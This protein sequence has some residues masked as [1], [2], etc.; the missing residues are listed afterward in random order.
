[1][2]P[3][4]E[5]F[6]PDFREW[7]AWLEPVKASE[8][9]AEQQAALEE[10]GPHVKN[11]EFARLLVREASSMRERGKLLNQIMY[12]N[13]GLPRAERELA[14]T[15]ESL[16]NGCAYCYSVHARLYI[17]LS[18]QVET[19]A[20]LREH[21]FAAELNDRQRAIVDFSV[22]LSKTPPTADAADV[23]SLRRAGLTDFEILDLIHVIAIFAWANRVLQTLGSSVVVKPFE[24]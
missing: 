7:R 16:L 17:Q 9:S 11:S 1:M 22:K 5:Q 4:R 8:A 12:G 21:G 20:R 14:A 19:I 13:A 24:P 6:T 23:A 3:A 10:A 18:K 2:T 15:A